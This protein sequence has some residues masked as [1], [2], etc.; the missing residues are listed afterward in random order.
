MPE[1]SKTY[2]FYLSPVAQGYLAWVV[3]WLKT[4]QSGAV[5]ECL[6]RFVEQYMLN[7]AV[8]TTWN[9]VAQAL[10]HLPGNWDGFD[11]QEEDIPVV[12]EALH[13]PLTDQ[14]IL[15]WLEVLIRG[16]SGFDSCHT[17]P[18]GRG[19]RIKDWLPPELHPLAPDREGVAVPVEILGYIS[20]A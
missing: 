5:E 7:G 3:R 16:R 15:G 6:H 13:S 11:E 19:T 9:A 18:D 10:Q 2:S 1:K 20:P 12:L 4:S 8:H 17:L 14:P